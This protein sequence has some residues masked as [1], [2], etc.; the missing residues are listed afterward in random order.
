MTIQWFPGHMAKT[1][2]LIQENL[3]GIDV[4]IEI[5]DARIPNSSKNPLI[6]DL[7]KGKQ[8]LVVLNKSD[9]ADEQKT[10]Q[11]IEYFDR[12][13]ETKAIQI[14]AIKDAKNIKKIIKDNVEILTRE[15]REKKS[16]KRYK[17]F[18]YQNNDCG[19]T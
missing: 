1:K 12:Q 17:I 3:K 18:C 19:Y 2:R 14:N 6:D 10:R 11:W 5:L 13:E 16:K 9:L 7:I 4:V 15:K 8:R